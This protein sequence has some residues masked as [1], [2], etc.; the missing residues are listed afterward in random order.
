MKRKV[1]LDRRQT[2]DLNLLPVLYELLRTHSVTRTAHTLGLTQS[3]VSNGLKRLRSHYDDEL[4]VRQGRTLV[5]TSRALALRPL[6]MTAVPHALEALRAEA[7]FNPT[8]VVGCVRIATSDHVDAVLLEP[9]LR[10]VGETAPRLEVTVEPFTRT[11]NERLLANELDLLIAP[12]SNVTSH[13]VATRI[14]EE[15]Y[16]V[17]MRNGHPHTKTKLTVREYAA[18][19]HV[20]VTPAGSRRSLIDTALS[21]LKLERRVYRQSA[22]F[23]YALLL[24]AESD[25]VATVPQSILDRYGSLLDLRAVPLP[26]KI[27]PACIDLCWT[28]ASHRD[29]LNRWVRNQLLALAKARIRCGPISHRIKK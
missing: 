21:A 17:V 29:P 27:P 2:P 22:Y 26:L 3:A 6:V 10:L 20:L 9:F 18:L 25:L 5:P 16:A 1:S 7:E 12:R 15:P 23:A 19:D 8:S 14:L 13:V 28:R 24:V 11:A 4:L